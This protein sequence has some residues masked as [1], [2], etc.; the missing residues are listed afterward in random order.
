[1]IF[2]FV[3]QKATAPAGTI[4]YVND[5]RTEYSTVQG[6]TEYVYEA[7]PRP[8]AETVNAGVTNNRNAAN[9]ES[10]K[11]PTLAVADLVFL[12]TTPT[13]E[14]R[15]AEDHMGPEAPSESNPLELRRFTLSTCDR[16]TIDFLVSHG[17]A[18]QAALRELVEQ[19]YNVKPAEVFYPGMT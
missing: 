18:T 19:Y 16:N 4:T 13:E 2:E 3:Y 17:Y 8:A 6:S 12:R 9:A 1:M 11:T 7:V 15:Y 10:S 5:S 14:E